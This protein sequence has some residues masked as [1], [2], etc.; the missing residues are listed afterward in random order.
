MPMSQE[1][2]RLG[3]ETLSDKSR[4]MGFLTDAPLSFG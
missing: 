4:R 2:A 3:R 1:I